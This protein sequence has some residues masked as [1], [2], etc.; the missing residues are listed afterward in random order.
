MFIIEGPPEEAAIHDEFA[1]R[2][3]E[4]L[5]RILNFMRLRV[6]DEVLA[7]DLTAA[8]FEQALAHLDQLR[9]P[10]AFGGWL[11]RIARNQVAQHYRRRRVHVPLEAVADRPDDALSVEA[12]VERSE[13]LTRLLAA[14]RTLSEREQEI[15][16]LK[17]LGGLNNKQ[18]GQAM[19]LRAGNVAV[20]LYRALRRL[21][22]LLGEWERDA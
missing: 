12:Q 17:F 11:F 22:D 13:E 3:R 8:T 20:I 10:E 9:S 18:I 7:Q 5:P 4:Y 16:G 14:I 1:R 15:I 2:Y 21:R 6:D 19:G